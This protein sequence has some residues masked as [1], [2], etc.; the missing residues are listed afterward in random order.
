MVTFLLVAI[1]V[2]VVIGLVVLAMKSGQRG[3]RDN[4]SGR[5]VATQ[6]VQN[7]NPRGDVRSSG[8][9]ND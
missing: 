6:Q 8:S 3:G 2:L 9:A 4:Q 7:S 1:G 5:S